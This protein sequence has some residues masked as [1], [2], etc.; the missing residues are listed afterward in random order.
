MPDFEKVWCPVTSG[1]EVWV[2]LILTRPP[3][4]YQIYPCKKDDWREFYLV[5]VGEMKVLME[6]L[7]S[8]ANTAWEKS[9][10]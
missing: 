2:H 10:Y 4:P 8:T 3:D 6:R 5:P 7:E 1:G 9:E